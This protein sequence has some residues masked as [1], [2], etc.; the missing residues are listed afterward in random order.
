MIIIIFLIK[1]SHIIIDHVNIWFRK[2]RP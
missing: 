1:E 2:F